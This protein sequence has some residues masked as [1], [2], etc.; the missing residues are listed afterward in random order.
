MRNNKRSL[1][2]FGVLA[3]VSMS[4]VNC[5]NPPQRAS[6][7]NPSPAKSPIP[8]ADKGDRLESEPSPTGDDIRGDR[9]PG[10]AIPVNPAPAPGA[11]EVKVSYWLNTTDNSNCLSVQV[12]GSATAITAPCTGG[13]RTSPQWVEQAFPSSGASAFK[14]VLKVETTDKTQAKATASSDNLGDA[15]WRWRCVTSQD[16]VSKAFIHTACYEDGNTLNKSFES[17][18]LFVQISGPENV[19]LGGIQ[20]TK[21]TSVDLVRC[22]AK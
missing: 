21:A 13:G 15:S 12:A 9:S 20:C 10:R 18:D 19:D 8:D 17:S 11:G 4:V 5:V 22:A 16:P 3:L 14:A 1:L 6:G 7:V 2:K